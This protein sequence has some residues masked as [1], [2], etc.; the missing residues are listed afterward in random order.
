[1]LDTRI[2]FI[3]AVSHYKVDFN[4]LRYV[5][6]TRPD[7]SIALIGKTGE[8]NPWTKPCYYGIF[9]IS[10]LGGGALMLNCL[11]TLRGYMLLYYTQCV[12]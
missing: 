1:M 12:E 6:K 11:V 7:W 2:S 5:V 10:I 3:G 8:G 4:L 9:S